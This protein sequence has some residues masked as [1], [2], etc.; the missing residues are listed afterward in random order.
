MDRLIDQALTEAR[1]QV[2]GFEEGIG[3]TLSDD[4]GELDRLKTS[5]ETRLRELTPSLPG[6][7]G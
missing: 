3:G 5:L 6:L 4:R 1:S 7:P 2:A